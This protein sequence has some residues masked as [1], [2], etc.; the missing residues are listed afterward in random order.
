[1]LYESACYVVSGVV[2]ENKG[3]PGLGFVEHTCRIVIVIYTDAVARGLVP[4]VIIFP[5]IRMSEECTTQSFDVVDGMARYYAYAQPKNLGMLCIGQTS[6]YQELYTISGS[7]T[8][9]APV[10]LLTGLVTP[11]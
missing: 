6:N 3:V 4:R 2:L 7:P 1:M 11:R 5:V 9:T 10:L 8:L